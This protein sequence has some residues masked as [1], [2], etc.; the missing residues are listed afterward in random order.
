MTVRVTTLKGPNAGVYY[1]DSLPNYYLDAEG[2]PPGVWHGHG[3]TLLGLDGV[4]VDGA[5]KYKNA[6]ILDWHNIGGAHPEYFYDDAI[7]LRPDGA[8]AYAELVAAAIA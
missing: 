1:V 6:V 4:L 7:H 2:E 5:K 3:A 8:T